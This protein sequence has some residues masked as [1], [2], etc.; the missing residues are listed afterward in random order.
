MS[1]LIQWFY[2]LA[3]ALWVGGM[4]FFSFFTTPVIFS[5][6]P[7]EMA[8]QLLAA[9]F[10]R[11]YQLGYGCGGILLITALLEALL[12]R[13]LPW[14]RLILIA[15]MMGGTLYAG[16]VVRPQVHDL[17]VEMRTVEEETPRA[18]E[19]KKRFSQ[20]HRLSVL[21]NMIVLVCGLFLV[22][23]LAFRLRL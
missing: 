16:M 20:A 3:L 7:K 8:G 22:G 13:H 14:I 4:V 2:I 23:I 21:L 6:L 11:Y 19:L 10:P 18:E 5:Q 1:F 15:V 12:V 17:K 9:L